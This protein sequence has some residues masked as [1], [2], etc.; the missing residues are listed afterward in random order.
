MVDTANG[1]CCYCVIVNLVLT[2]QYPLSSSAK[3]IGSYIT[4]TPG[5]QFIA[6]PIDIMLMYL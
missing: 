3:P 1:N 6:T 5:C 2:S 4:I